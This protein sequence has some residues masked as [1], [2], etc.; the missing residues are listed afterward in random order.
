MSAGISRAQSVTLRQV[1]KERTR[2][3]H[4]QLDAAI[5][6]SALA[7]DAGYAGFLQTQYA[8]RAPIERWARAS[9]DPRLLPPATAALIAEDLQ[10]LG[11]SLPDEESFAFPR[12]ADPRGLAWALGGSALGNKAMLTQR[13]RGGRTGSDLFLSDTATAD[14][15]RHLLPMLHITVAD[16]E[17]DAAVAGAEAVF[18]T[19][20]AASS[21]RSM[22]AAA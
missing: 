21:R 16:E 20:L 15:F 18:R 1:L 11:N 10:S 3:L 12:R 19:F 9:L 7:S 6:Q 5:G 2:V 13:R 4:D 17:A 22:R 8:A 14:F